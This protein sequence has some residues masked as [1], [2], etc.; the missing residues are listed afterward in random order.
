MNKYLGGRLMTMA[1]R[2]RLI[3]DATASA[4][5]MDGLQAIIESVEAVLKLLRMYQYDWHMQ[6]MAG[7]KADMTPDQ[8][9]EASQDGLIRII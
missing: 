7:M 8:V 3:A 9:G 2:L 1:A 6:I 4:E 5:R